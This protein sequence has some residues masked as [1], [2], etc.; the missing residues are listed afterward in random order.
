MAAETL[1]TAGVLVVTECPAC[2]IAHAI[3]RRLYDDRLA[4][5]GSVYC[6][7]GHKWHFCE[8]ETARLKREL[9]SARRSRDFAR[10]A[11]T[12]ERDQRQAAERSASACK[13]QATRIRNR[14][15]AGMCPCC[16]RT[17]ANLADHMAGQHPGFREG[18]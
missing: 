6:P 14:V 7:A 5:G 9:A 12:H 17:F 4:D 11:V 15:A 2:F 10:A 16:R 18:D 8:T 3:P 1:T 13:G